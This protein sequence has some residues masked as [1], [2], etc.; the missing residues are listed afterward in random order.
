MQEGNKGLVLLDA[1][2]KSL[3][4]FTDHTRRGQEELSAGMCSGIK[5]KQLVASTLKC[6]SLKLPVA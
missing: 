3:R 1:Y 4:L 5:G 2:L 6:L